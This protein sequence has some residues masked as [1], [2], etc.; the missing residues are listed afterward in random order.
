MPLTLFTLQAKDCCSGQ[1]MLRLQNHDTRVS[2]MLKDLKAYLRPVNISSTS[3]V[4]D[5]A[6]DDAKS[7][8]SRRLHR[9]E[10][11]T[12]SMPKENAALAI[13]M[14]INFIHAKG[15]VANAVVEPFMIR[16]YLLLQSNHSRKSEPPKHMAMN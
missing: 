1:A 15:L 5:N 8:L 16:S 2:A 11:R 14:S 4:D 7:L 3:V 12:R 9:N 10:R 13:E 6:N